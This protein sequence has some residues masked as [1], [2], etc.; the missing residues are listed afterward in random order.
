MGKKAD[1][2]FERKTLLYIQSLRE[3][4]PLSNEK[5]SFTFEMKSSEVLDIK[6]STMVRKKSKLKDFSKK[7]TRIESTKSI[8]PLPKNPINSAVS[9]ESN[10]SL[11]F[12]SEMMLS[13]IGQDLKSLSL[14][15]GFDSQLSQSPK[16]LYKPLKKHVNR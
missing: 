2:G 4:Q 15:I 10:D 13:D 6:S 12:G 5:P 16:P 14:S 8:S 9:I 11:G 1:S 3:R 7:T